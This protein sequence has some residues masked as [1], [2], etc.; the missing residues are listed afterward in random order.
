MTKGRA[1]LALAS[2]VA[3]VATGVVA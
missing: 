1:V 3:V 2:A